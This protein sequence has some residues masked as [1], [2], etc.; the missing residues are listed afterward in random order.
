MVSILASLIVL[1]SSG[2]IVSRLDPAVIYVELGGSKPDLNPATCAFSILG[3]G[4]NRRD[5]CRFDGTEVATKYRNSHRLDVTVTVGQVLKKSG[6]TD[7][8]ATITVWDPARQ[9]LSNAL[10]LK[11]RYRPLGG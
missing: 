9:K 11:T 7:S 2:P 8:S 5:R 6:Q 1:G 3:S 10:V 4:F